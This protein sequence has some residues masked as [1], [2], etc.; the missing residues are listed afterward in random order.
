MLEGERGVGRIRQGPEDL[1]E[2]ALCRALM[3]R[4]GVPDDGH[5]GQVNAAARV[6]NPAAMP[7]T[8]HASVAAMT[9]TAACGRI[10]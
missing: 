10:P 4:L 2:L 7:M 6:W 5:Y 1:V 9:G 8:I 3:A